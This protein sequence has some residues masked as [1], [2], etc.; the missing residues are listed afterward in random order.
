MKHS[1]FI[2][3]VAFAMCFLYSCVVSAPKEVK[4]F[5]NAQQERFDDKLKD[6]NENKYNYKNDILKKEYLDS[7]RLATGLYMDSVKLFVNWK[8]TIQNISSREQNGNIILS[9]ELEYQP[10]EYRKVSF[11][12]DY[13]LPNKEDT[14]KKDKIYTTIR[15]LSDF[16]DVYFDGFIRTKANGEAHYD[17]FWESATDDLFLPYPD[18]HFFIVDINNE[19]KGDTLSND[20]Q[21]AVDLSFEAIEPLKL[22]FRK[23]ISNKEMTARVDAIAPEFKSAKEKLSAEDRNYINRLTNAIT[24]NFLYAEED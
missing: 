2:I 20:L 9:F 11:D 8:A 15:S 18:F 14:L 16:S 23:E 17:K 6:F 19:S 10:E 24:L 13:V 12:V 1:K 7:V 5:S 3:L 22:N 4:R 21:N